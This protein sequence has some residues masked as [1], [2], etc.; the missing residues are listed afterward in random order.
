MELKQFDAYTNE[1]IEELL[2]HW[3]YYYGT[4][5]YT[6]E[7]FEKFMKIVKEEPKKAFELAAILCHRGMGST[8]VLDAIRGNKTLIEGL[9]KNYEDFSNTTKMFLQRDFIEEVVN[10]YNNPEPAI[11]IDDRELRQQIKDLTGKNYDYLP[12][13]DLTKLDSK[14]KD[15]LREIVKSLKEAKTKEEQ[16]KLSNQF[17]RFL[18]ETSN[19]TLDPEKVKEVFVSCMFSESD[20][21]DEKP[22]K[23]CSIVEG[24]NGVYFLDT[25]KVNK[26]VMEIKD[27]IDLLPDLREATS[28]EMLFLDRA[29]RVW[30]DDQQI[31]EILMV[32][33]IA[34]ERIEYAYPQQEWKAKNNGLPVLVEHDNR[35]PGII[36]GYQPSEIDEI[37][38]AIKEGRK[39]NKYSDEDYKEN[40]ELFKIQYPHIEPVMKMSGYSII[41]E[42]NDFYLCRADGEKINKMSVEIKLGSLSLV[43]RDNDYSIRYTYSIDGK[44]A[45]GGQIDSNTLSINGLKKLDS[46]TYDGRRIVIEVGNGLVNASYDPRLEITITEPSSDDIITHYEIDESSFT[47]T[48]ENDEEFG[49]K[50]DGTKRIVKYTD[51]AKTPS[52]KVLPIFIG[53]KVLNG[54]SCYINIDGFVED[55]FRHAL[56]KYKTD[57]SGQTIVFDTELKQP[58]EVMN[59][60]NEYLKTSRVKNLYSHISNHI[61]NL[62]PGM[63]E[64]IRKSYPLS[65][66]IETMMKES[67]SEEFEDRLNSNM[68]KEANLKEEKDGIKK[69]LKPE[70]N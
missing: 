54:D 33:G 12:K 8:P 16:A 49:N 69:E 46:N 22:T 47:I 13:L 31:V 29:G 4:E 24:I 21:K 68:L 51:V 48:I 34:A 10:T 27:M 43:A 56:L 1:E 26:H 50:E 20:I 11:P 17:L 52:N 42:G 55:T 63:Q 65:N 37:L 23:L 35:T 64:F 41:L 62:L 39:D 15:K 25:E 44:C 45:F 67:A 38:E 19:V 57:G 9:I 18:Q 2:S 28:F 6:L 58:E 3:F 66:S 7:E 59:V 32:L 5:V 30:T 60:A 70:D 53:E 61:E 14:D 36:S 40:I